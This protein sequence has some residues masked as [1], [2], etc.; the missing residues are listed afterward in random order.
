MITLLSRYGVSFPN[1][2]QS[3]ITQHVAF[4]SED[5]YNSDD[6]EAL[7][8]STTG[9]F[10]LE[11]G[12]V[13]LSNSIQLKA[14][15]SLVV[16]IEHFTEPLCNHMDM[17]VYF[18]VH[19]SKMFH[20]YL[21]V[22]L[23]SEDS[24]EEYLTSYKESS[25]E[26]EV[27]APAARSEIDDTPTQELIFLQQAL[28][29]TK[30]LLQGIGD[31]SATYADVTVENTL[32]LNIVMLDHELQ[33]ISSYLERQIQP[34]YET[35]THVHSFLGADYVQCML[36]LFEL[37]KYIHVVVDVLKKFEIRRCLDDPGLGQ[38]VS[39]AESLDS[40]LKRSV[41]TLTDANQ[42]M[43]VVKDS[44]CIQKITDFTFL[45]LFT[46]LADS[47]PFYKF[48]CSG[49]FTGMEGRERFM[50]KCQLITTQL[51]H[52]D[53]NEVV[54]NHLIGAYEYIFPFTN[55]DQT[56][57]SLM[58]SVHLLDA[59]KGCK[60]IKTV[61]CNIDLIKIWFSSQPVSILFYSLMLIWNIVDVDNL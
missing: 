53:Y 6:F 12:G 24:K 57:Q 23:T 34:V 31:G 35:Y 45:N 1:N 40:E 9:Q 29:K 60:Q 30:K 39:I 49:K 19:E 7:P 4:P 33:T 26:F 55:Q 47:V 61:N 32:D 8:V 10:K 13:K 11:E 18:T 20:S 16:S 15:E 51:Q 50:D 56:L 28:R 43:E 59:T 37:R 27:F 38:L 22:Y 58:K 17:L 52:V 42:K 5:K 54:L 14:L 46:I 36:G 2:L 44:L 21:K 48:L 41:L 3:V 25:F